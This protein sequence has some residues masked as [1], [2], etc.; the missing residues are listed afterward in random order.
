MAI[1]L[2]YSVIAR[3][4]PEQAWKKFQK[5]EQWPWWNRVIGESEWL[6]GEPWKK[7]SRFSMQVVRP[8]SFSLRPEIIE[9]APPNKI[10]WRGSGALMTGENWFHFEQNEN[11]NSLLR[12]SAEFSGIGTMFWGDKIKNDIIEMFAEWLGALK[13]EAEKIAREELAKS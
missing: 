6:E 7:G 8:W 2:E 5:L 11:G 4:T 3:C 9:S 10:G 12:V 1:N 13:L